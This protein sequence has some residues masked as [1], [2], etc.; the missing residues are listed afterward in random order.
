M[1]FQKGVVHTIL[2]PYVLINDM[3]FNGVCAAQ[4]LVFCTFQCI[5]FCRQLFTFLSFYLLSN[6]DF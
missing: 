3:V 2:D 4:S 1:F 5:V 6:Y